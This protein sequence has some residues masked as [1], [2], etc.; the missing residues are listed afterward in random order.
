MIKRLNETEL[1]NALPLVWKVF[2]D[3]EAVYYPEYGKQ[4]FWNAIHSKEYLEM[5]TAYGA[6]ED[7]KLIGIIATRNQGSHIGLFFVDG[8]YHNQG[9]GR[10]LWKTV[11]SNNTA[12]VIHVHS[13]L[14]AVEVYKKL[15]FVQIDTVQEECG[16][17]YVPMEYKVLELYK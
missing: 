7:E 1:N 10:S 13:S 9:I 17:Q 8:A 14:Y 6:F 5:L 12:K 11:I 16:I 3:Y 2:C 15:G 4:A